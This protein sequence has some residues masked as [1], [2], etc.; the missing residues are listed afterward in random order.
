MTFLAGAFCVLFAM[1]DEW[2]QSFVAGRVATPRDVLI[3]S[4]GILIG[5]IVIRIVCAIG[6]KTIFHWFVLDE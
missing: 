6:R 3:D 5:L 1:A 2:H 4:C